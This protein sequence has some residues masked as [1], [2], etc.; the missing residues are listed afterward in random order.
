MTVP[1]SE[2]ARTL[3]ETVVSMCALRT[4]QHEALQAT[5]AA[6]ETSG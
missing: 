5:V 2:V 3:H 4:A 1:T 6:A